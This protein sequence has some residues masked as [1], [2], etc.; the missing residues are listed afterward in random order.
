M[1]DAKAKGKIRKGD[2]HPRRLNPEK[3]PK[4]DEHWARKHPEKVKRKEDPSHWTNSQ[5]ERVEEVYGR[6]SQATKGTFLR[7]PER[8]ARGDKSGRRLHPEKYP[9]G[10]NSPRAKLTA[11]QVRTIRTLDGIETRRNIAKTFGVTR[12]SIDE[13]IHRHTYI[14]VI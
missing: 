5:P 8:W 14:D 7:E 1:D 13:I 3:W 11:E 9:A 4:G 2:N 6:I 12:H 10:V